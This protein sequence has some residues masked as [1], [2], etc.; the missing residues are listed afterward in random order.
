VHG[1]DLV[2]ERAAEDDEP[3]VDQVIHER[4]VSGE[5]GLLSQRQRWVPLRPGPAQHHVKNRHAR[6]LPE[7]FQ[8]ERNT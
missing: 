6:F 4:S 7:P 2:R 8:T 5:A 1:A 3:P